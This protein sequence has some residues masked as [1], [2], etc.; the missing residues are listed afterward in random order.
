[1]FYC[2]DGKAAIFWLRIV[3]VET[4]F[5]FTSDILSPA[6]FTFEDFLPVST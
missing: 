2:R 3:S 1:M 4:L 6:F 5:A